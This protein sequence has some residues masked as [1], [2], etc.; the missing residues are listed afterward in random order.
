MVPCSRWPRALTLTNNWTINI[1]PA[2]SILRVAAGATFTNNGTVNA[3]GD[4]LN[5]GATVNNGVYY[6]EANIVLS[7][8][9]ARFTN[10]LG[11]VLN[12]LAG[13]SSSGVITNA[14]GGTVN[15]SGELAV[16]VPAPCVWSGAGGNDNWSNAANWANDLVP[17][18]EHPVV[19]NGEGGGAA[20]VLLNVDLALQAR[21][22]TIGPGDTLTIGAGA[23]AEDVTLAVKQPAGL[24]IN[25][26]TVAISNYSSLLPDPLA[27]I[28]NVGGTIRN[29]CRGSAPFGGVIGAEV[30]QAAC[31]WDGG[32]VTSNWS[33]A[34]NWDSDTVPTSDDPVLIGAATA[35]VTGVTLDTSFDLSSL[36]IL[37]IAAGQTLNVGDGVTLRIANQPPGGSIWI[38]GVLNLN[39]G[40]LHN[41][42]TGLIINHGTINI[43]GGTLNNQGDFL[44]NAS[45]GQINNVG[46][47]ISNGAGASFT[48]LGTLVNDA[49]S[50]FLHGDD[51]T[52]TN[53]GAFTNAG[54]FYTSSRGGD[55]TNWRGGT[56]VNSGTLNQGG[57]G[58]FSNMAGSRITN[59]GRINMLAS[60]YDNRRT[61]ENTGTLEVFHF[62]SYQNRQGLLENQAGGTFSNSGSVSN[63]S[64]STINNAGSIINNRS[65]L[66]AGTVNNACGGAF[67][68]PVSGNQPVNTC[69]DS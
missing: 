16:V 17:P 43:N 12:N 15:D 4:L 20:T 59:S 31:F 28:N 49:G 8:A 68:G 25:R 61:I 30:V 35:G 64:G 41:H 37:T 46:G 7:G 56:L 40:T 36:G 39:G 42:R 62:G 54:A 67:A 18:E 26:G 50:T 23:I 34:A 53:S 60:L 1:G 24:L 58:T 22:L 10:N 65:L 9:S 6:N 55:V 13:G 38:N 47:L 3:E 52:L 48:N 2:D 5:E 33:E 11:G 45:D 21:S 19:I 57:L 63:S 66:N 44:V 29:A 51:A 69:T 27:T 32:G 14:C